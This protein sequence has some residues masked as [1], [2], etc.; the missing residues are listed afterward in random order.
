MSRARRN[1]P[2]GI[3]KY[4]M[5][6]EGKITVEKGLLHWVKRA[7]AR[8]PVLEVWS[9]VDAIFVGGNKVRSDNSQPT[10]KSIPFDRLLRSLRVVMTRACGTPEE[11]EL[12]EVVEMETIVF[13]TEKPRGK[14]G[15][16][17]QE[18]YD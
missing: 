15:R 13:T 17:G 14:E 11:R 18:K 4:S 16:V 2:T 6:H 9:T 7:G 12:Y 8:M 5:N 1:Y 10:M 3:L